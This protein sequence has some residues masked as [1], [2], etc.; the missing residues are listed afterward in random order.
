VPEIVL[1]DE[2]EVVEAE[3]EWEDDHQFRLEARRLRSNC[4]GIYLNGRAPSVS[5][6]SLS[7]LF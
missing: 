4:L 2:E 7:E 3:L 5:F 1:D 6:L